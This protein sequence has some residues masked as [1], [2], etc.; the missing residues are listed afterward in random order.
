MTGGYTGYRV[1][2]AAVNALTVKLS[3]ELKSIK[4]LVNC[5]HPSWVRT[6]METM[7]AP[8]S[9]KEGADSI[10]YAPPLTVQW[11]DR[12]CIFKRQIQTF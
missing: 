6:R 3:A 5:V 9:P 10:N 2:K 1:S 12:K 11:P 8:L 4:I 7:V